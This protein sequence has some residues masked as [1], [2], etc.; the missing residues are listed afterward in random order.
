MKRLILSV[1]A[2]AIFTLPL[3][4]QAQSPTDELFDKYNGKN[5]FTTVKVTKELFSMFAHMESDSMSEDMKNVKN[6]T[7]RLDH[8]RILMFEDTEGREKQLKAFREEMASWNLKGYS[9]L[10]TVKDNGDEVK[11]LVKKS[12]DGKRFQEMLL[13]ISEPG[14]AG[15]ISIKGDLSL[16]E[17]MKVGE[18][19]DIEMEGLGEM[20]IHHD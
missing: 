2:V 6:L 3:I 11:F 9:E 13:I 15:F 1:I 7:N 17:M 18:S 10:M 20:H 5:G 14:E 19:M 16:K 8:I 12:G 4:T